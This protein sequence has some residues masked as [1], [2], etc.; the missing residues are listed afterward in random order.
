MKST[1]LHFSVPED[2]KGN[3]GF[4]ADMESLLLENKAYK[5]VYI[6][7]TVVMVLRTTLCEVKDVF[8]LCCRDVS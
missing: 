6:V 3:K 1:Q 2:G 5:C 8:V 7:L 4:D